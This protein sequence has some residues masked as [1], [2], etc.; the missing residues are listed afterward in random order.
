MMHL[1]IPVIEIVIPV[2]NQFD[3][4]SKIMRTIQMDTLRWAHESHG[5]SDYLIIARITFTPSTG[6]F[7]SHCDWIA[8]NIFLMAI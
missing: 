3:L 8:S 1:C 4:L 6:S 5:L 7:D 2:N